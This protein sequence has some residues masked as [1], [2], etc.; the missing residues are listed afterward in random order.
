MATDITI[1]LK[2]KQEL[3]LEVGAAE[4]T[5]KLLRGSAEIFGAELC[6]GSPIKL[7]NKAG[8]PIFTWS[9]AVVCE[10]L[11]SCFL[12]LVISHLL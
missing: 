11:L 3:R 5:V 12:Y 4:A 1:E 2:E 9:F 8:L 10:I 6:I 7:Q